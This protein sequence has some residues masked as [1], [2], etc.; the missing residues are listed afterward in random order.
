MVLPWRDV[1]HEGPIHK[2]ASLIDSAPLRA[3][4]LSQRF[5]LEYE[6]VFNDFNERNAII[7]NWCE[8]DEV[9]LWFEHDLYDQL[10]LLVILAFLSREKAYKRTKVTLVQSS[11]YLGLMSV[12]DIV[13]LETAKAGVGGDNFALTEHA[14]EFYC[15]EE[16]HNWAS[17][18]NEDLS[19]FPFLRSSVERQLE[20]LPDVNGINRTERQI[21]L[22]LIDNPMT[23][24]ELFRGSQKLE[25]AIF[26]GDWSFFGQLSDL[27]KPEKPITR[28]RQGL[29]KYSPHEDWVLTLITRKW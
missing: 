10:Q 18:L 27:M 3:E 14:W 22:L 21:L 4:Y 16:P 23:P 7:Q 28:F 9:S 1:L 17:L 13:C 15:D 29:K 8:F 19:L 24:I 26:L 20:E 11:N 2:S 6:T 12:E 25:E 5:G